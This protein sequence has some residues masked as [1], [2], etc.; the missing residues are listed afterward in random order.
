MSQFSTQ[1]VTVLVSTLPLPRV[2]TSVVT[3][4]TGALAVGAGVG[5]ACRA[6]EVA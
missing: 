2:T 3:L 4:L 6:V 1:I 5:A